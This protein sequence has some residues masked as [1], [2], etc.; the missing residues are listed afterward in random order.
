MDY[1]CHAFLAHYH[2]ERPDQGLDDELLRRRRRKTWQADLLPLTEIGCRTDLGGL[3]EALLSQSG[4]AEAAP[5]ERFAAA[6]TARTWRHLRT[7]GAKLVDFG[8]SRSRL[9]SLSH[10]DAF[11]PHGPFG[12][13]LSLA[14]GASQAY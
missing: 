11:H 2:A 9:P 10:P 1:L 13:D 4:I 14:R 5:S 8:L 12:P 6:D 3:F 7:Q